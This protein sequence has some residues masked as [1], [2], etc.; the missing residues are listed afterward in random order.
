MA[1]TKD[2]TVGSPT[3]LIL[4]FSLPIA[5]GNL[6]QQLYNIVD[7][8]VIGRGEGV[9]ALAAVSG[10][11]WLDWAF[12][13]V[14]MGLAQGFA[15]EIAQ[16]FGAGK[17][18]A[19]RRAAGQG[20]LL[21][22][23]TVA[24]LELLSQAL[25]TPVLHLLHFPENTLG[26]TRL[27]L[28]IVFGGLGLVMG[29]NLLAGFLQAVGDSRTPLL[30]MTVAT[31]VNVVLD[32]LLVMGLHWGV[33]GAAIAM[34][35]SQAVS[36]L[37][38]LL[39]VIR[40]PLLHVSR[41]DLWPDRRVMARL[42]RLGTPIAFGNL[43]IALGGL[44]LQR[45]V[46]GFG[47]LIM[48]G[49]NAASR[50]QGLI[51]LFG[52]AIGAGVSTFS[53]QNLGARRLDRVREGVR[54]ASVISVV[55]ALVIMTCMLLIGKPLLAL[56]IEDDPALVDQVLVYGYRFLI[57]MALGLPALYL[58]FSHRSALQGLGDTFI[59]MLSGVM[60]LAMRVSCAIILPRFLGEWGIYF[61]E[62]AAWIGAA[63]LLIVGYQFRMRELEADSR[64]A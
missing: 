63:I 8:L 28:R 37:I 60:E 56:F 13:S 22:C 39:A 19:L 11:G 50:L 15:I 41:D 40:L 1:R 59:P 4:A 27:Y 61:S 62:I 42:M 35:T 29:F 58:L 23:L 54:K 25:V 47:F 49:Y 31:L 3:R 64:P 36:F 33:A 34:V 10:S 44:V 6:L 7:T 9:V 51:E 30:A 18:D 26:L 12:L 55:V 21:S 45:V 5:A 17:Y 14:A 43:I 16:S 52:A 53:G 2:M 38:T 24:V 57:F 46:N 48:A 20:I 32:V